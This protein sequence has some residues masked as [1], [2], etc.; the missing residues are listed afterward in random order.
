MKR[1]YILIIVILLLIVGCE[2]STTEFA[3]LRDV[4]LS[5]DIIEKDIN[6]ISHKMF[7]Y[8]NQIPGPLLKLKQGQIISVNFQNNIDQE[9]TV[10]WHGLRHNN[11]DDGVPDVTQE[12]VKPG[13]NYNYEVYVPDAGI[14]WYHPHVREDRQQDLGLAGNILVIPDEDYYNSV[15][16]EEALVIDDILIENNKIVSYPKEYANFALMGRFGN[17]MLING[18]TDYSL[19]VNK[20]DVIRFYIT[21][22]ANVRP[23]NLVF[24]GGKVKLIGSDIG[25]YEQ[26]EYIDSVIIAPAERYIIEVFY[27][28]EGNFEIKNMNPH[29]TYKLGTIKVNSESSNEDYSLTFNSLKQNVD[30][31]NDIENFKQFFDKEID[32]EVE[33]NLNMQG[34]MGNMQMDMMDMDHMNGMM[35]DMPMMDHMEEM[36]HDSEPI[37]W[38]DTM[39]HMNRMSTSESIEWL[40][41]DKKTGKQ[42]MDFVMKAK[43]GDVLKIRIHNTENSAHPMQHPIHLHGQRF[44]VLNAD[45]IPNDNL[46]WKDTVLV[47]T[48]STVDI[49]VDVT[50]PGDWMFHCHISEHLTAGMM[51]M[52]RVE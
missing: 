13:E 47:P 12:S 7:A 2:S 21:N 29:K 15:N 46:V 26:E 5:A 22:V 35:N 49:L 40:I 33:L 25:K 11:K 42:N 41:K 30:I 4:Q 24:E 1:F 32:Y 6:G 34:M 18:E 37:E 17:V 8:N 10:H 27:E 16:R 23:F 44:L 20:G 51:S 28:N 3:E 45:G 19:E 31:I 48:G 38:E 52:L 14:Y 36:M 39:G 50:N 9:T 43:V